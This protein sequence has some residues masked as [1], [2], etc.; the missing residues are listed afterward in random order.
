MKKIIWEVRYCSLPPVSRHCQKCGRNTKFFCSKKFRV[1]AQRRTL[2]V[3]LIYNCSACD[4]TWNARVYSHISPQ[5]LDPVQLEGF[6]KNSPS[7]A[8]KYAVDRDFLFKNGVDA[9]EPPPHS[10]IGD[11]FLLNENTELEIKNQ[12]PFPIKVSALVREKLHLSQTV[13]LRLVENG[14]ITSIPEQDLKKCQLKSGI[15][16]IF[17][18]K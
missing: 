8:E 12:Y 3:W 4:T 17:Q 13:Y 5:S 18:P 15:T 1:N 16:L 6:H 9:V 10:I 14:T 7:L 11:S 2:D